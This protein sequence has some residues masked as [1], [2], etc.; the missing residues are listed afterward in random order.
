MKSGSESGW[1]RSPD[2]SARFG[3]ENYLIELGPWLSQ[4]GPFYTT[5]FY[6]TTRFTLYLLK[7]KKT[8]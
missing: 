2:W 5:P 7:R 6:T 3:R 1:E 4:N 8:H